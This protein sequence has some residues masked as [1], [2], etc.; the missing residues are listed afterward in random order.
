M[1]KNKQ[2][3]INMSAS[4]EA[5]NVLDSAVLQIH[6]AN[7]EKIIDRSQE[8]LEG[9]CFYL[10]K[11]LTR[12]SS[13][14]DKQRNLVNISRDKSN[15][16]EIGFNGGHSCL[17]F[18]LSNPVSKIT[19]F[20]LG[21]HRY[22]SGCFEY[23]YGCF[24][25][26]LS[27]HYGN[28]KDTI[29]KFLYTYTDKFDLIHIDGGHDYEVV[30]QD[31]LNC[32]Y[33]STDNTMVIYDDIYLAVLN[34]LY[35][36]CIANKILEPVLG[37]L[38]TTTY[39]HTL[40]KYVKSKIAV[41]SLTVGKDYKEYTKYA[42]RSNIDYCIKHGYP[43]IEDES[44]V[45]YTR[46]FPWSKIPLILKHLPNYDYIMWIDGD[47]MIMN[48]QLTIQSFISRLMGDK[49]LMLGSDWICMNTG[50][51]FIKNSQFV[52]DFFEETYNQKN[53][54]SFDNW[55]QGSFIDLYS[56]NFN[57]AK[58]RIAHIAFPRQ[59]EFNSYWYN[60]EYGH[61]ILHFAGCRNGNIQFMV[62]RFCKV[63]KDYENDEQYKARMHW[64]QHEATNEMRR[65]NEQ[66]KKNSELQ[67]EENAKKEKV[68]KARIEAEKEVAT[69]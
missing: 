29:K 11:T 48:D 45:D 23:L 17:L 52:Y 36:E 67:A 53:A 20:D 34:R 9:N 7:L 43:Y 14:K 33:L 63:K 22:V 61:F 35:N 32:R 10:H 1:L 24:P 15:I 57:Q 40:C 62:D 59:T 31:V 55:E 26:R 69:S 46:P 64:L 19:L 41:V 16:M 58:D 51:M 12:E 68:E 25:N 42:R 27:I 13:L 49:D 50:V 6:L 60:Y 28:S 44:V 56:K 38:P 3:K 37:F 65:T 30:K 66:H 21:E 39:A 18:L 54:T 5:D 47:A 8:S 2:H 4:D